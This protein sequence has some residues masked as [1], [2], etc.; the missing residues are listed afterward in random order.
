MC[1]QLLLSQYSGL[2]DVI[3]Q[4]AMAG[5]VASEL[6]PLIGWFA[7]GAAVRTKLDGGHSPHSVPA[8]SHIKRQSCFSIPVASSELR[9]CRHNASAVQIQHAAY[10]KVCH[11][12]CKRQLD[13]QQTY[14]AVLCLLQ[15]DSG[16]ECHT[17]GR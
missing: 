13:N 15:A 16:A 12:L 4:T 10:P 14:S 5:R 1:L 6:E 7:N 17:L 9:P 11:D 8:Y 2:N 3:V